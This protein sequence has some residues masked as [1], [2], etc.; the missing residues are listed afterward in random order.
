MFKCLGLDR[1]GIQSMAKGERERFWKFVLYELAMDWM[2]PPPP[3]IP[4]LKC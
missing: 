1:L 4:M 2:S 3:Q